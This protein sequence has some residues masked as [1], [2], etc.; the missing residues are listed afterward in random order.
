MVLDGTGVFTVTDSCN[1]VQYFPLLSEQTDSC[2]FAH[3]QFIFDRQSEA[4]AGR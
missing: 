4:A 3:W 2:D 1:D